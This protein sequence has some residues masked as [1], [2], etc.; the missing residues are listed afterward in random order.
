MRYP[1]ARRKAPAQRTSR[2][3]VMGVL[4][5][6]K[7]LAVSRAA[8]SAKLLD[9]ARCGGSKGGGDQVLGVTIAPTRVGA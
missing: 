3:W 7:R 9:Q 8:T 6:S 1:R 4:S 2:P 5:G